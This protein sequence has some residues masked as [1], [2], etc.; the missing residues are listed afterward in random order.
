MQ[1]KLNHGVNLIIAEADCSEDDDHDPQS[2][3]QLS[4]FSPER[5]GG[6]CFTSAIRDLGPVGSGSQPER[7][8]N[9]TSP[10]QQEG[11]RG[12]GE[13]GSEDISSDT[14]GSRS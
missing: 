5:R 7:N 4:S 10:P 2:L 3:I 1:H 9:K 14:F 12:V 6:F 13:R 11:N 8:K